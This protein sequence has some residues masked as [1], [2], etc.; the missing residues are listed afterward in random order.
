MWRHDAY[1]WASWTNINM[2]PWTSYFMRRNGGSMRRDARYP[3][4]QCI[5]AKCLLRHDT[6]FF[7]AIN[8]ASRRI[9]FSVATRTRYALKRYH[10]CVTNQVVST[11]K[12][13][14]WRIES[15]S[16]RSS[17]RVETHT[18]CLET[19]WLMRQCPSTFDA[20]LCVATHTDTVVTLLCNTLQRTKYASKRYHRC[21]SSEVLSRLQN[22]LRHTQTASW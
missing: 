4:S 22:A 5:C 9:I 7:D 6:S 21:A 20:E 19:K 10:W 3:T 18:I 14:L 13:V 11:L 8:H 17:T 15:A 1:T 16:W 12:Y 2:G